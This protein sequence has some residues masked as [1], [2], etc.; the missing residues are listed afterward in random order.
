MGA[1]MTEKILGFLAVLGAIFALVFRARAAEERAEKAEQTADRSQAITRNY[2]RINT[3]RARL[4]E[5]HAKEDAAY[6]EAQKAGRRDHFTGR[7]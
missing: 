7:Y 5:Q 3:A 4:R 6:A 2:E 1:S